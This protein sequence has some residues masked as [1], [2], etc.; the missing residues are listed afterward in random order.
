MQIGPFDIRRFELLLAGWAI[1]FRTGTPG[2]RILQIALMLFPALV[3]GLFVNW[4]LALM[5]VGVTLPLLL[6]APLARYSTQSHR[7]IT[8]RI[9]EDG[10]MVET[11]AV[12]STI[13][14]QTIK[15]IHLLACG[16]IVMISGR[17]GVFVPA[18]VAS[19]EQLLEFKEQLEDRAAGSV[20]TA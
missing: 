4:W 9:A 11:P 2:Y 1:V 14:S 17:A 12:R 3:V 13:L 19:K 6:L 15:G 16:M 18:R 8:L 10:L 7:G 5:V 20:A